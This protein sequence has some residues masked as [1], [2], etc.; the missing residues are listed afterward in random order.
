MATLP[1]LVFRVLVC[2]TF[3]SQNTLHLPLSHSQ[4]QLSI[5]LPELL[6][7]GHRAQNL[8]AASPASPPRCPLPLLSNSIRTRPSRTALSSEANTN[9]PQMFTLGGKGLGM[10]S[11]SI[12]L[13]SLPLCFCVAL[14]L[15]LSL[16]AICRKPRGALRSVSLTDLLFGFICFIP[17]SL[18]LSLCA[19]SH[20]GFP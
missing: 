9:Q 15:T 5:L 3:S 1:F 11:H 17:S 4:T 20:L 10:Q 7:D 2:I 6:R 8:G 14:F 18:F 12:K 19:V 16:F 13:A